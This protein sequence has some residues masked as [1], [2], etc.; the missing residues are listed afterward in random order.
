ML[1]QVLQDFGIVERLG[2]IMGDNA[3]NNDTLC[4]AILAR[5]KENGVKWNS[6]QERLRYLGHIINL[7]VQAFLFHDYFKTK[8]LD[9]YDQT[10]PELA[11]DST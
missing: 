11:L 2:V 5:L 1:F 7:I 3:S 6:V 8:E 9:A 10:E 4:R